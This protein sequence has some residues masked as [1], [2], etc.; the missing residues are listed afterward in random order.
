MEPGA[1]IPAEALLREGPGNAQR[2]LI[3]GGGLVG[4]ET[5][6]Y[7]MVRGRKVVVIEQLDTVGQGLVSLRRAL[8]LERLRDGGVQIRTG[9]PLVRLE[10]RRAV[11]RE[12]GRERAMDAFDRIVLAA[13]YVRD[14]TIPGWAARTFDRVRVVGDAVEPRNIPEA[15][16]TGYEAA[17]AL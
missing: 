15:T 2:F 6:E 12:D 4:L 11:I 8:I 9:T 16:L 3:V 17:L 10:E 13:G 14:D 1:A 7:L 5:A